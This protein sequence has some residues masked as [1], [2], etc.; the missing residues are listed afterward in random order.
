MLT[1]TKEATTFKYLS[2]QASHSLL[3][4]DA[5]QVAGASARGESAGGAPSENKN[6]ISS[7]RDQILDLGSSVGILCHQLSTTN[8]N[9]NSNSNVNVP[10][11]PHRPPLPK[12][13]VETETF[14]ATLEDHPFWS[15]SSSSKNEIYNS[16]GMVF[17]SLLLLSNICKIDLRE[18][19]LK[20]ME[21]NAR[22]YPASMC[23]GRSGKYTEYSD[24]TGITKLNQS[25]DDIEIPDNTDNTETSTASESEALSSPS[26]SPESSSSLSPRSVLLDPNADSG[27]VPGVMKLIQDFAMERQWSRYHTP[28]N[29]VLAMMGEVG[30]LAEIFQWMGDYMYEHEH[31]HGHKTN[32]E[33]EGEGEFECDRNN[34][35]NVKD[36]DYDHIKQELAD[37]AIYCLRLADVVG[38]KD[39]GYVAVVAAA[40]QKQK[41]CRQTMRD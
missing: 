22:K 3:L 17:W 28:R 8:A 25:L 5:V 36:V 30:E 31:G 37:V 23:K 21:L 1:F 4:R 11:D 12:E 20:K 38:I 41:Q 39:L 35:L 2:E 7:A 14:P 6:N 26:S 19:I 34:E 32:A 9:A 40:N 15:S 27:S 29:I 18:S 24:E 16:I 33:G 10:L 13:Q